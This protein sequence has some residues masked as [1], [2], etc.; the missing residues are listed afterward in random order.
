MPWDICIA[1]GGFSI[2][3][4]LGLIFISIL[5]LTVV[6]VFWYS[7]FRN[8]GVW[9]GLLPKMEDYNNEYPTTIPTTPGIKIIRIYS[10]KKDAGT[11]TISNTQDKT[12][13]LKRVNGSTYVL[14][15]NWFR[16]FGKI[17][18]VRI[19]KIVETKNIKAIVPIASSPQMHID[20]YYV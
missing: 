19:Q 6:V 7:L 18:V 1:S 2:F 4:F 20:I 17:S 12:I 3:L 16:Y 5:G 13:R 11:G 10:R 14:G 9:L 15:L 8:I